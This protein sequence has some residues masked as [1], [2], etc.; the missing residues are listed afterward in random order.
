[1]NWDLSEEA[2][3]FISKRRLPAKLPEGCYIPVEDAGVLIRDDEAY[4]RR[5]AHFNDHFY[6][7]VCSNEY[8]LDYAHQAV[9]HVYPT[10][11]ILFLALNSA[12]EIDHHFTT[13]AGINMVALAN[14][15]DKL[16]SA[17]DDYNG[18][19]KIAVWHNPIT[20]REAMNDEFLQQLAVNGFQIFMHGHIHEAEHGFYHYDE[21]RGI[22]IVGAGTF[23]APTRQQVPGIPLQYNLLILDPTT[24]KVIVETRKKEKPDGAWSADA[25]WGDKNSPVPR[26]EVV[27]KD[28]AA[29]R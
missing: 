28:W 9:L 25:R 7:L 16:L 4:K 17:G 20:G 6:K 24:G 10:N 1:V 3:R 23:G 2:Y 5:F 27:V 18:W 22:H 21:R 19:L 13:R 8:P 15:V 26:Y 14:A 12:W 29:S 11:R